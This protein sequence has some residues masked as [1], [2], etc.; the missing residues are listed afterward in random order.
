M[1]RLRVACTAACASG[2]DHADHRHRERLLQVGEAG[3]GRGVARDER[4]SSRP[5][6]RGTTR[7]RA[8][9]GG[10]PPAVAARTAGALRRRGRRSPR[11]ASSRGTRGGRS[12]RPCPS[13]R[14]R[15]A[16]D[17]CGDSTSGYAGP[18]KALLA[19]VFAALVLAPA[20]LASHP[21]GLYTTTEQ[22]A[23][24]DDGV[25]I[26]TT[27]YTPVTH[28]ERSPAVMLFHGVGESKRQVDPVARLFAQRGYIA[29][30][31]DF[32]GHGLSG[33]LFSGLGARELLDVA[34]LRESWL[35][36]NAPPR[37]RQGRRVRDLARR[38]SGAPRRGRRHAVQ[39]ARGGRDV[40][41]PLRVA[42]PAGPPEVG[43]DLPVPRR[44]AGQPPGSGAARAAGLRREPRLAD[45]A[46]VRGGALV[47]SAARAR[48]PADALL[49]GTPRLRVR[50]R[51]GDRG[52][53]APLRPEGALLRRVRPL[54]VD[55]PRSGLRAR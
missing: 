36:A 33:G 37:R 43:R 7:S 28:G 23:T 17:P 41:R 45:A 11:A 6:P 30:T 24:M 51:A 32:R 35:P 25:G 5:A 47:A 49:P 16:G 40:D 26:A 42:R 18:M 50:A 13:R 31:F 10:S 9:T 29:L 39:G 1:R 22:V 2:C 14:R 15:S 21:A 38:R 52:L 48:L 8:R 27:L 12:A 4:R 44:G 3:R 55:A 53:A 54:A 19:A 20:A 46:G 34:R